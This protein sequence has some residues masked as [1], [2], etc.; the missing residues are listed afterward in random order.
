MKQ[1]AAIEPA[2]VLG[3][4][5][6]RK[7]LHDLLTVVGPLLPEHILPDPLADVPVEADQRRIDRAGGLLAGGLDQGPEVV[8]TGT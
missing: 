1:V 5:V 6:C 2:S 7:R 3:R 4:Q 8:E